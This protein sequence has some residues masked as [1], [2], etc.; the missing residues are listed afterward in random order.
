MCGNIAR[1][2]I[3]DRV[4]KLLMC[5]QPDKK[6]FGGVDMEMKRLNKQLLAKAG[7]IPDNVEVGPLDDMPERIIQF[8]EG[9]F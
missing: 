3:N 8:G 2:T 4:N 6:Y 7:S 1:D 9:N 5:L